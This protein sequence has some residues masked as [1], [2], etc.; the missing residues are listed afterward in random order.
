MPY[1]IESAVAL[2]LVILEVFASRYL[3]FAG[4]MPDLVLIFLV[5]VVITKGQLVAQISGFLLGLLIDILSSGTLGAHALSLTIAG[6][7]LGYFYNEEVSKQRL[8][9][10]PFLLFVF[11][12]SILNSIIYYLFFTLGSGLSFVDYA[13]ERGGLG[14][15]LTVF[16][17]IA[18]MFYWSRKPLY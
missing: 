4:A 5:Y 7:L 6:F 11:A 2:L 17:A 15:L 3:T 8:R 12:A 14:A 18:P 1:L 13:V 16:V 9:N 10:W